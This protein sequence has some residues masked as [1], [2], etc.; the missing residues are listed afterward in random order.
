MW[1]TYHN[2][3]TFLECCGRSTI[4]KWNGDK[5]TTLIEKL[6]QISTDLYQCPSVDDILK[7][8]Q[9]LKTSDVLPTKVRVP[10]LVISINLSLSLDC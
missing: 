4:H 10:K 3:E 9:P 1:L 6:S 8:V 2:N 7:L 5:I